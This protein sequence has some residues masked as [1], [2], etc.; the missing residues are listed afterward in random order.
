[1]KPKEENQEHSIGSDIMDE[2]VVIPKA[3]MDTF[4][5]QSNP[6]DLMALYQFYYYTAKRQKTNQHWVTREYCMEKLQW[7]KQRFDVAQKTLIKL[8]YNNFKNIKL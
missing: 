4:L 5:K 8:G 2:P 7:S 6:G 3:T 1:M